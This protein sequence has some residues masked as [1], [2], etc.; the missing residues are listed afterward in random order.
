MSAISSSTQAIRM[1]A[2]GLQAV[3]PGGFRRRG[4]V[5]RSTADEELVRRAAARA[6][7]GDEE[8][9]RF[10]Y[11]QYSDAVFAYVSSI[12]G[13]EHAAEDITQT[14]FSRLSIRLQRY[15]PG[16]APF[17]TWIARVARNA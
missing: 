4:G 12:L 17:G 16:E 11:L 3:S 15:K 14:I 10:L 9:L 6:R 8:A 13:D 5:V 2:D 7:E 1:A